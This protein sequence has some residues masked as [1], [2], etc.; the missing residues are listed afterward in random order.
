MTPE[1]LRER[2]LKR[3]LLALVIVVGYFVLLAPGVTEKAAKAENDARALAQKGV[4]PAA[5]PA[6]G[7]RRDQVRADIARLKE[8]QAQLDRELRDQLGFLRDPAYPNRLIDRL[9]QV[10]AERRIRVLEDRRGG[11]EIADLVSPSVRE[12]VAKLGKDNEKLRLN[13]WRL[14]F[15]GS[16]PDVY[17]ALRI[18]AYDDLPVLP[19]HL[20]MAP[21]AEAGGDPEWTL[22]IATELVP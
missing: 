12:I 20:G 21:S 17:E 14:R 9:S 13:G 6:L 7:A 18:L 1:Q 10:L 16:Y 3:I 8:E 22:V 5:I 2:L 19:L 4:S 15:S 11:Q